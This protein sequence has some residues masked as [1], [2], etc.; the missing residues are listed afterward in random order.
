LEMSTPAKSR[1]VV[2]GSKSFLLLCR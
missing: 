1:A 2:V